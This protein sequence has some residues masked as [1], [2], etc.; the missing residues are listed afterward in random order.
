[1]DIGN[2]VYKINFRYILPAVV[3]G[4]RAGER[5]APGQCRCEWGLH[6]W[7]PAVSVGGRARRWRQAKVGVPGGVV[8][9][10]GWG[11]ELGQDLCRP[12]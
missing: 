8:G 10:Q 2:D 12:P 5:V 1:M 3:A 11:C 7:R 6:R 9:L 4:S